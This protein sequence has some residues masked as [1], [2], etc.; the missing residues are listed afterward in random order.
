M[1]REGKKVSKE[2]WL[3]IA[4]FWHETTAVVGTPA[5]SRQSE[6]PMDK[7]SP[8]DIEDPVIPGIPKES[9]VAVVQPAEAELRL[10]KSLFLT[11]SFSHMRPVNP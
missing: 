6:S 4:F 7:K 9:R 1:G 5:A 10:P 2:V 11:G 8:E 3:L